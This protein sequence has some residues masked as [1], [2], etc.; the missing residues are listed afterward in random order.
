MDGGIFLGIFLVLCMLMCVYFNGGYR[1]DANTAF[2]VE[3]VSMTLYKL[4]SSNFVSDYP[5]R[6][7]VKKIRMVIRL[8]MNTKLTTVM[9]RAIS[10]H[11]R[12]LNGIKPLRITPI[13]NGRVHCM[14][15]TI[16]AAD[17][18]IMKIIIMKER[19]ATTG[20]NLHDNRHIPR[21]Q[22]Y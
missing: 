13:D 11:R 1:I 16:T 12:T 21:Q 15:I 10:S 14:G 2:F 8:R 9:T 18:G 17:P 20:Q 19:L 4:L 6:E 22:K 5:H 7:Y 3:Q